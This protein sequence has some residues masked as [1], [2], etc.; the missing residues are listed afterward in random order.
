MKHLTLKLIFVLT[1]VSMLIASCAPAVQAPAAPT[2]GSGSSNPPAEQQAVTLTLWSRDSDQTLVE[3]LVKQWNST[4]KNQIETTIIPADQFV[5]KFGTAV[6]GGAAPDIIAIDLIYVPAFSAAGQMTDI[7]DMAKAIPYF[8]KLSPSHVRLATFN[9]KIYALPFS[10]EGSVLLYNKGLFKQAG[11]DPEKPPQNWDD[12]YADATAIR[13]LG[14]DIYGY[15]FAG[16]CAGCNAFTYLPLIWASGGDILSA[17]YSQATVTDPNVKAA[18]EFYKKMW[19]EDLIPPGAKVDTGTDFLNAFAGGKI[20][21]A[22]SGAFS[23]S[24]LKNDH[25]DVDFG[26]TFLPGQKGG[27]GSFA[28]GDSIG[29]PKGSK[30]VKEAFEFIQWCT[31]EDVQL[32]QFAKNAQLPVRTDLSNNKYFQEDPRLKINAEAMALGKTPYSV[33]YNELFNDANGPWLA[34]IQT[35]IFEGKVDEAIQTAQQRFTE[36]MNQK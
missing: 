30:Y 33:H 9:G 34:M 25:P 7:T 23:I 35:A 26:M 12:I 29:I 2:A 27:K 17:D 6:A 18:L 15:Y 16:A 28:G 21:M 32:E 3:G 13:K 22:G 5:T 10:A 8:D 24:T 14:N 11:L 4:H 1:I 19:D 20:G 36:I 31:T